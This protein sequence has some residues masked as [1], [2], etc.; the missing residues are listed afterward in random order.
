MSLLSGSSPVSLLQLCCWE[1]F[2]AVA[3]VCGPLKGA[4]AGA[5]AADRVKA[6]GRLGNGVRAARGVRQRWGR[7][8]ALKMGLAGPEHWHPEP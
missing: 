1:H 7:A 2:I 4:R 3:S 5:V 8:T 6:K